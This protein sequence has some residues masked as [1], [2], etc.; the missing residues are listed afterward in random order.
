MTISQIGVYLPISV[1]YPEVQSDFITFK[2][3]LAGLSRTDSLFWCARVNMVLSSRE[4]SHC[5][6]QEFVLK[7]FLSRS[8]ISVVNNFCKKYGGAENVTVFFRGQMLE[9]IRWIALYCNDYAGDGTTFEDPTVR[10]RFAQAAL[11]AGDFWAK[12]VFGTRFTL[13]DGVEV[14]RRRA[15]GAIRKSIEDTSLSLSMQQSLGRGWS[16]FHDYFQRSYQDLE[17]EF[18]S[19]TGLSVEQYYICLASIAINFMD[20]KKNTGIFNAKTLGESTPYHAVFQKYI[21]LESQS[22]TKLRNAL[23]GG[24]AT[25]DF[26]SEQDIPYYDYR[27]LRDKPIFRAEDGRAII[28]D[29]IMYSERASV[30]PL[31]YLAQSKASKANEIFSAYGIAFENYANDILKRM[32]DEGRNTLSTRLQCNIKVKD[33]T[34]KN[35]EIDSC[36]NDVTEMV[37]FE[38]KAG[39]LPEKT[40]LSD[41][42]ERY[43]H[44][45]LKKYGT[46][47]GESGERAVKGMGQLARTVNLIALKEWSGHNDEFSKVER[48]YPVLVV[49]DVHLSAPIYGNYFAKEFE[50]YLSL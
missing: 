42:Y 19:V 28:L 40:I 49:H 47:K 48:I 12:R 17:S 26:K 15:L 46:V 39:W 35:F 27:S 41:N 16:L 2:S 32:F 11:I 1:L 20:P 50:K 33:R 21:N 18:I 23:W 14:G 4:A 30:G 22:S 25:E 29:S 44:C 34:G 3:L 36:L 37:V 38:M 8:E 10:K 13:R 24:V 43:L 9:L 6:K 5:E 31:F 7:Q 45:L